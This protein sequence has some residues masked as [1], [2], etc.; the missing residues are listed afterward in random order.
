MPFILTILISLLHKSTP[1]CLLFVLVFARKHTFCNH[2]QVCAPHA[3]II[4]G[5]NSGKFD[6]QLVALGAVF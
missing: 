2:A 5:T 6:R 1:K 4:S 3:F